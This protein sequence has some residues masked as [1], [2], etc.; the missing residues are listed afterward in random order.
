MTSSSVETLGKKMP[1]QIDPLRHEPATLLQDTTD[2]EAGSTL[3]QAAGNTN[4]TTLEKLAQLNYQMG[5]YHQAVQLS[6]QLIRSR[7]A[8]VGDQHQD[9]ASALNNLATVYVAMGE[10]PIAEPLM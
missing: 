6:R 1:S 4:P 7:R 3:S 5:N 8:T 10:H 9:Y 2:I